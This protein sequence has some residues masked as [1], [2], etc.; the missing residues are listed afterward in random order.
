LMSIGLF[1]VDGGCSRDYV[2]DLTTPMF[3]RITIH[4]DPAYHPGK[5]VVIKT[6]GNGPGERYIDAA[7]WNG[8]PLVTPGIRYHD[9]VQGGTLEMQLVSEPSKNGIE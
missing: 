2:L 1:S 4:L 6:T 7:S 3:D 8:K 5:T 9:L